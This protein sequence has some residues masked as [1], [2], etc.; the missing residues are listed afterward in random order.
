MTRDQVDNAEDMFAFL[1]TPQ[2]SEGNSSV[3]MININ[4]PASPAVL[5]GILGCNVAMIYQA[6]QDGKLPP[7]S[8]ASYRDCIKHHVTFW[9]TKSASKA[10]NMTEAALVQTIQLNRAKTE[11]QWLAIKK[12]RG[13]LVDTKLLAEAFEPYFLNMRMQLCS[14][15]RKFPDM[16]GEVD[17][18]IATWQELGKAMMLK[19]QDEL[20]NFIQLQMEQEI[21]LEEGNPDEL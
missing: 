16:Q 14:I 18:L 6:R 8:D 5:S 17:K 2:P 21:E 7:N 12:E 4:G 10:N 13:E 11:A 1:E 15:A 3:Q 19:S 9:K 20:D